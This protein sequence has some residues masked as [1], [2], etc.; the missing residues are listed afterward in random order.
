M[1][2]PNKPNLNVASQMD[3]AKTC[4][5]KPSW[6]RKDRKRARAQGHPEWARPNH[7]DQTGVTKPANCQLAKPIGPKNLPVNQGEANKCVWLSGHDQV[8]AYQFW[9]QVH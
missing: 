6:L 2:K 9:P 1:A 4:Y 3:Q 8:A 7:L 5:A